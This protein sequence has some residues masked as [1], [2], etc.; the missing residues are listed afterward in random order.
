[1]SN[2][3]DSVSIVG[4]RKAHLEQLQ[5]YIYER[6]LTDWYYGPKEQFQIRHNDLVEW[7]NEI[8]ELFSNPDNK[9]K[10]K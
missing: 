8:V 5:A 9:I 10:G 7:I 6:D 3:Y 1:M 4:L 2:V